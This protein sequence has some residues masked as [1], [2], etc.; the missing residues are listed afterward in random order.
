MKRA[1][2]SYSKD[3]KVIVTGAT[4]LLGA[5][6]VS[7]LLG[8]GCYVKGCVQKGKK[9]EATGFLCGSTTFDGSADRNL[10]ICECD[11]TDKETLRP[12]FTNDCVCVI[13]CGSLAFVSEEERNDGAEQYVADACSCMTTLLELCDG[14]ESVKKLV[15]ASCAVSITDEY[16]P[17]K[18][19]TEL[20]W[21]VTSSLT[22]RVHAYSK[23]QTE[24]L[25]VDYAAQEGCSFKLA[26]MLPTTL[27]GPHLKPRGT[28]QAYD[29]LLRFLE[30]HVNG[31]PNITMRVSDV[32]DVANACVTASEREDLT[33]RYI[34]CSQRAITLEEMLQTVVENFSDITV[35]RR[36]LSDFV[37]RAALR[38]PKTEQ[39]EWLLHN[40]GRI[41]SLDTRRADDQLGITFRDPKYS[42]VDTVNHLRASHLINP[43]AKPSMC[44]VL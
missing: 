28:N 20:D 23:T 38:K 8:K 41:P 18:V 7:R 11:L 4:G 33:G 17:G 5:H 21:N 44:S 27:L 14:T 29:I 13:H 39:Q 6:V 9:E 37:V 32:R 43:V 35:P 42:V 19:Y 15:L 31:I 36:K 2:V 3:R 30:M 1:S 40:V 25:A 10:E 24:R 22:R 12:I 34:L 26:C 16:V